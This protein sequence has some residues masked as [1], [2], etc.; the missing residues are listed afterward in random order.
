[1]LSIPSGKKT[2]S[3]IQMGKGFPP[4]R[5]MVSAIRV[6][7]VFEYVY[8]EFGGKFKASWRSI[9]FITWGRVITSSSRHPPRP[10]KLHWSRRPD[11][12]WPNCRKVIVAPK[13]GTSGMYLRI[14]SS[15]SSSPRSAKRAMPKAV[16]CFVI[17]ATW[18]IVSGSMGILYS[19]CASPYALE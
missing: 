14:S 12:W 15:K 11:V 8:F 2:F 3:S 17:E 4:T 10:N 7:P 16:N 1:M 9:N 19:T 13:S 5:A 6:K 18:K